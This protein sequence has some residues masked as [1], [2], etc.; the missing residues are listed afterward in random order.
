MASKK[1]LN[2]G[3]AIPEGYYIHNSGTTQ[4]A[5]VR[6]NDALRE[7]QTPSEEP[8]VQRDFE[9]RT[10]EDRLSQ[11]QLVERKEMQAPRTDS[12][13][14]SPRAAP[15]S[16]VPCETSVPWLIAEGLEGKEKDEEDMDTT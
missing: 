15:A 11:L 7:Q 16:T 3:T 14:V 5:R 12:Q 2:E 6:P 10:A 4:P 9:M 1:R 13:C 8:F